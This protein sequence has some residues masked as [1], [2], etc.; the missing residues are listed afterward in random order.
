MTS[1]H[2]F[3]TMGNLLHFQCD[4]W[5]L[6]TDARLNINP[7]WTAEL[8]QLKA[9]IARTDTSAMRHGSEYACA[10]SDWGQS[11]PMPV[12]TTVP[13]QGV[14][15]ADELRPHFKAFLETAA[16]AVAKQRRTK[17]P[18]PLL[19]VPLFGTGHA[20]GG[21]YRGDILRALLE[22]A[23]EAAKQYKVDVAFVLQDSAAY[24]LAQ[25]IRK[26][27]PAISWSTLSAGLR[28]QVLELAAKAKQDKLV[29]FMGAGVSISAGAP[30][31]EDLLKILANKLSLVDGERINLES[32]KSTVDRATIIK[33]IFTEKQARSEQNESFGQFVA[34][35]VN[36]RRY[37][38]A[39]ALIVGIGSQAAITLN[40]DTLYENAAKDAGVPATVIPDDI[41]T[42]SDRWLLK[43]HGS[44]TSPDS[45]VLTR[46][47]YLGYSSNRQALTSLV[48]AHLLTHH[49]LF[50]GFGLA[51]DHFHEI[52]FDVRQA[53]PETRNHEFGTVLALQDDPLQRHLW[54]SPLR[55]AGCESFVSFD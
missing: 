12:L 7:I 25:Q 53:L 52:I 28:D 55:Q 15:N 54:K 17:R 24:S 36:V 27:D 20:A 3:V 14:S 2:V 44:I 13:L 32:V 50:I 33:S 43:L 35:H 5:L 30:T 31:W 10:V 48:K 46:D 22:E 29:P 49:L 6:P 38:L 39:P 37:G 19:A 8:H 1:P 9:A 34:S 23:N 16:K 51:D 40:Y 45:I 21:I 26:E 4:A 47:D 41:S 11:E 18:L 42:D